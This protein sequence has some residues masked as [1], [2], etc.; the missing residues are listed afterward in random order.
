[1]AE[2]GASGPDD[3]GSDEHRVTPLELF[4]DLAFVFGFTQ[5]TSLVVDDPTWGG[6]FRGMLVLAALWWAWVGYAWF[7]ST[8]DVDE[9]GVRLAMLAAMGA[10]LFVALAV[11]GAFG[12]DALLF[13]IS[14]FAVRA[15]HLVLYAIVSRDDPDLRGALLRIVPSE[16]LGASLLVLAGFLEGDARIA[17]WLVALAV[18]YLGPAVMNLRGWRIAPDHFAERH[19]LVILIALGESII[20]IGVGAGLELVPEV[21]FAGALGIVVVSALWWLYFDVAAIFQRTGLVGTSGVERARMAR[22]SYSYLH[23]PMVAGIVLFAFGLE[24]TL[25]HV[26]D[27]LPIVPAVALCGGAALY[28]L[29]QVASLFRAIRHL[30]RRR[31][32]GALVLLALIPVAREVPA[33]A[34]L[35]G[36]SAVCAGVVA[37]EAIRHREHRI[38]VRHPELSGEG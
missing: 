13:G 9:G 37:Y 24:T 33:L 10:M 17:A 25:H 22:D 26:E 7:T 31:L 15:L 36:V 30:F 1:M 18:D 6:V 11:P 16:L 2:A 28:L 3:T 8:L 21:L 34:A 29:G 19:G 4:F 20:A 12:D 35:A 32:I 27:P 38:Q 5:V 14:Y 23:L